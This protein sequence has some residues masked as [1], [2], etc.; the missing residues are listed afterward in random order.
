VLKLN[1]KENN[2]K[3]EHRKQEQ[4]REKIKER[5]QPF[6]ILPAAQLPSAAQLLATAHPAA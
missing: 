5:K 6:P 3:I 4:E 1:S 2:I